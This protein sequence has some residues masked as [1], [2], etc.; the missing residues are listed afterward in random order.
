MSEILDEIFRNYRKIFVSREEELKA[1]IMN[2]CIYY[3]EKYKLK[4]IQRIDASERI[5]LAGF[6]SLIAGWQNIDHLIL[7]SC[8]DTNKRYDY[9]F[10]FQGP[11]H[12]LRLVESLKLKEPDLRSAKIQEDSEV[13]EKIEL[14][15]DLE[16]KKEELKQRLEA[17]RTDIDNKSYSQAKR[18]IFEVSKLAKELELEDIITKAKEIREEAEIKEKEETQEIFEEYIEQQT[19][20]DIIDFVDKTEKLKSIKNDALEIND[21]I[22]ATEDPEKKEILEQ[23]QQVHGYSIRNY[24]LVLAQARKRGDKDFVGVINS[25][26]NWKRQGAQVKRNPDKSK[27]YSYKIFV[28]VFKKK[29]TTGDFLSSFKI[30]NVFDISQTNRYEDYLAVKEH[31]EQALKFKDEIPYET[32][33]SFVEENFPDVI[34]DVDYNMEQEKGFYDP[35]TSTITIKEETSHGLFHQL[36]YY[37]LQSELDLMN[38]DEDSKQKNEIYAEITAYLLMKRFEKEGEYKINYDFGYS[39][40]WALNILDEFK[41]REFEKTYKILIDYIKKLSV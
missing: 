14:E 8:Q 13:V 22:E 33:V 15:V 11:L 37:I 40:V 12:H 34:I 24:L 29:K 31:A 17:V 39:N 21:K 1:F 23:L 7:S 26:W 35:E 32:A 3:F 28:P 9:K 6:Y 27:P 41:F 19:L 18:E 36:G 38:I 30:G 10:I 20:K 16:T 2:Y 25:Y 5:P 4:D